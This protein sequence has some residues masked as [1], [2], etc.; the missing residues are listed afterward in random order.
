MKKI[1]A[2]IALAAMVCAGCQS[3]SYTSPNGEKFSRIAFGTKTSI[4]GLTVESGTNGVRRLTLRGYRNDQ[5]EALGVV[6]DAAVRA[7]MSSVKP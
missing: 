3:T 4:A 2:L 5:V 7:A 1:S 6:T